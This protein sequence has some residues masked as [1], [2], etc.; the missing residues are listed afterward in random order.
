MLN[1]Y[2]GMCEKLKKTRTATCVCY[3]KY[4]KYKEIALSVQKPSLF[5][6]NIIK[7]QFQGTYT[8]DITI[9][10]LHLYI[11][12]HRHRLVRTSLKEFVRLWNPLLNQVSQHPLNSDEEECLGNSSVRAGSSLH[13]PD[14]QQHNS[15]SDP[16]LLHRESFRDAVPC[17]RCTAG[18]L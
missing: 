15:E 7:N 10:V 8:L 4:V 13:L 17:R 5:M 1:C 12:V 18:Y 6:H 16:V 9:T 2:S 3:H 14:K 11:P